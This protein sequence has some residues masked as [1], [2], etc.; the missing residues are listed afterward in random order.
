MPTT[1]V[2]AHR[3]R[4]WLLP[5]LLLLAWLII[6]GVGGP[7]AGKLAS[8]QSNDN[9]SFLPTNAESTQVAVLEKGFNASQL[10]PAVII[11]ER[12]SGITPTDSAFLTQAAGSLAG[13]AGIS[14]PPSP[15]IPSA[16][17]KA[18]EV[19]SLIDSMRNEVI[20]RDDSIRAL[21]SFE[22]MDYGAAVNQALSERAEADCG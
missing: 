2:R 9:A 15:P 5:A 17:G 6:A 20:V 11:A 8:V 7:F 13:N 1:P 19:R 4:R 21:V 14:G 22:P 10:I 18:V 12:A 3:T 16:D